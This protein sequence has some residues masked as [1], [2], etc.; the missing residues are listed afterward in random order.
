MNYRVNKEL[1][2]GHNMNEHNSL[3]AK[4]LGYTIELLKSR[5]VEGVLWVPKYRSSGVLSVE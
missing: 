5:K 3:T 1:G 2:L 4:V